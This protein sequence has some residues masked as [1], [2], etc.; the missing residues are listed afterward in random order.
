MTMKTRSTWVSR[1]WLVFAGSF[2]CLATDLNAQ[3]TSVGPSPPASA[4]PKAYASSW[5]REQS[6]PELATFQSWAGRFET[7]ATPGAKA[8][9][10]PEGVALAKQRRALLA[11]LIK[12][13]PEQALALV[14]PASLRNRLPTEISDELESRV[15]GIGDFSVLGVL[16]AINGPAVEPIQRLVQ[17]NGQTYRASVYGRRLGETTKFGIPLHGIVL[18]GVMAGHE[19]A[20]RELETDETPGTASPVIDR[21]SAADK[22]ANQPSVLGEMGNRIYRFASREQL[23]QIEARLEA[24]ESGIGPYPLQPAA[25]IIEGGETSGVSSTAE[26][27]AQ[28]SAWTTGGKKV[29]II[30]ID[31][32]DLTGAPYTAAAI[33]NLADTQINPFYQKSSYQLTSLTN[34]VTSLVYRMPRT[35]AYYATNYANTQLHS[36]ARTAASANY[37]LANYDRIIVV[38]SS[39]G[40]L[41]G[42]QINYGGLAQV[43]GPNV[44]CNGEFDFRVITH[45]L[46]HT[47][48]LYHANLWQVS[49]GN[50]I[51]SSGSTVEYGDDFDTMGANNVGGQ[52]T[53]FNP[54]F[55]NYLGWIADTQVVTVTTSG[56][57]RIYAFD[58][59]NY[60]AAPGETLALKIVKDGTYNYWISCRRDFTNNA[61]LTN[62]V[63]V[64]WGY[65]YNRQNNLLDMTTPGNSDQDAG[66]AIGAIFTDPA[67]AISFLPLARGGVAP[68]EYRDV[69]V[70]FGSLPPL[71]PMISS[72][73]ASQ[74]ALLGTTAVFRLIASGNPTPG[75]QWRRKPNGSSTWSVLSEG[76]NY[77]GTGTSNLTVTVAELA[78]SGDQFQCLVT[79]SIG[80]VTSSPPATLTVSSMLI[81]NTLAGQAGISGSADGTGTNAQFGSPAGLATDS[82][83]NVYVA[84]SYRIRKMT[85]AGVVTTLAQGFFGP[86]GVALDVASNIYVA[87]SGNRVIQ[88]VTPGGVKTILAGSNGVAGTVDGTNGDARFNNPWGIAVDH[89]TNI[90]VADANNSTIRKI[91]PVGT[92]WVVTTIAG[93]AGS[94]GSADGTNSNARF[95]FPAGLALDMSSNLYVAEIMNHTIRKI[96]PDGTGTNW[97]V[98]TLAGEAGVAGSWD[99]T[100][101]NAKYTALF[102]SPFAVAVDGGGNVYVADT[103]NDLIRKITPQGMVSTLA[104][105]LSAGTNVDGYYTNAQFNFPCGIAVDNATNIYVSDANSHTI[106]VGRFASVTVP[107]LAVNLSNHIATVSWPV[108]IQT[109]RLQSLT[110]LLKTNWTAVTNP[111]AVRNGQN[112]VTNPAPGGPR[113]FRLITP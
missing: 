108:P 49:D 9:L 19:D 13:N 30:R 32:P 44:W 95:N 58:H 56:T 81:I 25:E 1:V 43:G 96:T 31:F 22:A 63:Y 89:A 109:Y 103:Y 68:N 76:G 91:K 83:G 98:T 4:K 11:G 3:N 85:P 45:E 94:T 113:F 90:Y 8:G 77:S 18:D 40:G 104:G 39:L 52:A 97:I 28:S 54:W 6:L 106:R 102:Y 41:A 15:S 34:S 10:V 105:L 37:T 48:G 75:F 100:G 112:Y 110:N 29:L 78:M 59:D 99:N 38:F 84:D 101:S 69:Q 5:G 14:V 33:Q 55:K 82:D 12:S 61:S 79:N 36:D 20:L 57:Y 88:K 66:L 64:I 92:N 47:Y 86:E 67:A 71:A 107:K 2:F 21:R 87:D 16:P 74:A 93:L 111:P 80:S 60:L 35:A 26:L 27:T 23:R 51:S 7:A 17:L 72:G 42:S 53:D 62:G 46:G 24:A 65:N 50:P 73:P 70:V